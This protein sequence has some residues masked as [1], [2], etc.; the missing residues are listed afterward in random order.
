MGPSPVPTAKKRIQAKGILLGIERSEKSMYFDA[1][2][3]VI[4]SDSWGDNYKPGE[5]ADIMLSDIMSASPIG[6][7][8]Q[9]EAEEH[10]KNDRYRSVGITPSR[11][12]VVP[13]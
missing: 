4:Y 11:S 1:K 5:I 6:N 13:R 2:I 3:K 7:I 8:D 12:R 9:E 10:E